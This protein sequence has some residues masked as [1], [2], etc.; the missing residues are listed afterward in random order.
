MAFHLK[1]GASPMEDDLMLVV[2]AGDKTSSANS[3]ETY[4]NLRLFLSLFL[5]LQSNQHGCFHVTPK[6]MLGY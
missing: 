2:V 6:S 1:D 5:S 3:R 4:K